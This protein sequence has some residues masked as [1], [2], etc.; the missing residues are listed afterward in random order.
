MQVLIYLATKQNNWF[1]NQ[2]PLPIQPR[3]LKVQNTHIAAA[4][5]NAQLRRLD[6]TYNCVGMIFGARRTDI[7]PDQI[8]DIFRDDVYRKLSG[9]H[10]ADVGD[11]A[12]YWPLTMKAKHEPSHIGLVVNIVPTI[13][14]EQPKITILSKWGYLGEFFHDSHQ[15]PF[16]SVVDYFTDRD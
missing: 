10:L 11:L 8:D 7:N 6:S 5:P 4:H 9:P 16:G 12:V 1:F 3:S 15:S 13:I 2:R 14:N